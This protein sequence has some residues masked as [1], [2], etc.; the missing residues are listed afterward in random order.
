ME[1]WQ[2]ISLVLL[3][4]LI[5]AGIVVIKVLTIYSEVTS[6]ISSAASMFD[7]KSKK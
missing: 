2:I 6:I 1:F 5:V 4:F 7:P 3:V